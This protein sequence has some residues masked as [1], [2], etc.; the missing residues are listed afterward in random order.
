LPTLCLGWSGATYWACHPIQYPDRGP[1]D[2][3][4]GACPVGTGAGG[5]THLRSALVFLNLQF[6]KKGN[7]GDREKVQ[8]TMLSCA[9]WVGSGE[10]PPRGHGVIHE[11]VR[12]GE[13]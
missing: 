10:N 3:S 8:L 5:E 11:L 12:R 6:Q 4:K 1:P 9:C 7:T 13:R 2:A